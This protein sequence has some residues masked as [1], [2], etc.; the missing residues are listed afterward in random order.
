[1]AVR[2][3]PSGA[4][5]MSV[6]DDGPGIPAH[7]MEAALGAFTRGAQATRKAIDGAGLG[8]PI[9]HG[10]AKLYG[11]GLAVNSAPGQG[12]E[13]VITFPP[14]RVLSGPG[15]T[16]LSHLNVASPS[17]RRLIAVTS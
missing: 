5:S 3:D 6:G 9:V 12:T 10:L 17:Q 14:S 13:V 2:M 11:A 4:L 8:L 1:M 16:G 15:A 7:E